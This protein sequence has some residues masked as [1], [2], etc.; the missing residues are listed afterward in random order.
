MRKSTLS[1][2]LLLIISLSVYSMSYMSTFSVRSIRL[3]DFSSGVASLERFAKRSMGANYFS[4]RFQSLRRNIESLGYVESVEITQ[5]AFM[6][7]FV[8]VSYRKGLILSDKSSFYFY[9]EK[10]IDLLDES[11]IFPLL[12]LYI[13]LDVSSEVL[14]N[15]LSLSL[16][17]EFGFLLSLLMDISSQNEYNGLWIKRCEYSDEGGGLA[18]YGE[19]GSFIL[20]LEE[21]KDSPFLLAEQ[22]MKR[23]GNNIF[24]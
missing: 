15:A 8:S 2:S 21:L 4:R 14:S 7:Y 23:E 1:I 5:D 22:S 17:D 16:S 13:L 12:S 10:G 9:S 20:S 3:D 19:N 24:I 11:D 18:F 6:Q